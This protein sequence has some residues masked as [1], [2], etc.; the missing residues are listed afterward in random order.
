MHRFLVTDAPAPGA[1]V[2]LSADESHHLATVLRLGEG[3]IVVVLDG[4]GGVAKARVITSSSKASR[5]QIGE[6]LTPGPKPKVTVAFGLPKAPALEFILRRCAEVGVAALQPLETDKSQRFSSWN[7]GRWEK[8]LREVAK[9]CETPYF[10]K[11]AEPISLSTWLSSREP[12]RG[13]ALCD[14]TDREGRGLEGLTGDSWDLLIGAEGG[15]SDAEIK[16]LSSKGARSIGL[17][18][19]R[20]RTETAALV[21]L[22]FLKRALSEM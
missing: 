12:S 4:R 10:P 3:E 22:V 13:L 5:V 11:L 19:L 14:S 16:T 9:Q 21:A 20:L 7:S 6:L 1:Q 18:P 15:W 8:I 2:T 17:G